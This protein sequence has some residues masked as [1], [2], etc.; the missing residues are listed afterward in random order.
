MLEWRT[1]TNTVEIVRQRFSHTLHTINFWRRGI[2][3]GVGWAKV[4]TAHSPRNLMRFK[5]LKR[6]AK[7]TKKEKSSEIY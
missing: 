7:M 3:I 6:K 4:T 1:S 5:K 2:E